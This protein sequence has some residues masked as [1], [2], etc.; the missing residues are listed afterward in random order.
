VP[1]GGKRTLGSLPLGLHQGLL[2]VREPIVEH[3]PD[4]PARCLARRDG[5]E[6]ALE[7]RSGR[8]GR[9][10]LAA[11]EPPKRLDRTAGELCLFWRRYG[12]RP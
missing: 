4:E 2:R 10:R 6:T 5:S 1:A 7:P 9:N 12:V 8:R 11:I 3:P